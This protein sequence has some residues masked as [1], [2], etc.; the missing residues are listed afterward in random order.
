MYE[1]FQTVMK[2]GP[3]G[4]TMAMIPGFGPESISK[5]GEQVSQA[6]LKKMICILDS[7]NDNELDHPDGAKLFRN[8]P[9]RSA[10]IARGAGVSIRDV[11][12]LLTQY[13]KFSPMIK[14]MSITKGPSRRGSVITCYNPIAIGRLTNQ[15][16]KGIDPRVLQQIGGSSGL[17]T[18]IRQLQ[19]DGGLGK[20]IG[21]DK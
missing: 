7:M 13:S 14:E 21:N 4:Q 15:M 12:D 9:G 2:M 11:Q 8:Q 1:Q 5:S 6:R 10:R 19:Q 16:S 20:L 18:M 3:L 17:S